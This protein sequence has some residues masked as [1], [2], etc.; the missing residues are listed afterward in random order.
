MVRRSTGRIALIVR[1]PGK[2]AFEF[3]DV[4]Q[5]LRAPGCTLARAADAHVPTVARDEGV[6]TRSHRVFEAPFSL[7]IKN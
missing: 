5:I 2:H 6:R 7:V 3:G 4:R 1:W